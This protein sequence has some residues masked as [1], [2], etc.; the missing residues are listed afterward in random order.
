MKL[1]RCEMSNGARVYLTDQAFENTLHQQLKQ[2]CAE[3]SPEHPQ[4][5]QPERTNGRPRWEFDFEQDQRHNIITAINQSELCKTVSQ[6]L[7]RSLHVGHINL[8]ID[9]AGFGDLAPHMEQA[10]LPLSQIFLTDI[11]D[12]TAG[13]TIYQ[14]NGDMLFTLCYRDNY[15]WFFDRGDMIMHGRHQDVP[16]DLPRFSILIWW[17]PPV[18]DISLIT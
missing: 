3:F 15:G 17:G 12:D 18:T 7:G 13:T 11:Q 5:I 4:R 8:W 14:P 6:E 2:I 16:K 1:V 10:P 9:F